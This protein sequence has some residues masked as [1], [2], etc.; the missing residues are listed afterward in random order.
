MAGICTLAGIALPPDIEWE[1]E[2]KWVPVGVVDTVTIT[3]A[4]VRQG[5][6]MQAGRPITLVARGDQH[7]WLQYGQVE[8][9]RALAASNIGG[10]MPLVLIDGRTFQVMWRHADLGVEFSPVEYLVSADPAVQSARPYA[11]TLR[12]KQV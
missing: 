3:G 6:A 7:V 10:A 12:L 1:D 4:I 9:L 8:A 2:G 5:S 11:L